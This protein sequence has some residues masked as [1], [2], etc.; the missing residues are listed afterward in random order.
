MDW[1]EEAAATASLGNSLC[2]TEEL[3]HNRD[4]HQ[5]LPPNLLK[6][7]KAFNEI[8]HAHFDSI[9]VSILCILPCLCGGA[10]VS[11]EKG[12]QGRAII[13]YM[14]LL[15]PSGVGKTS[16]AMM[17]RKYFL[18]WL[19]NE[20]KHQES[21]VAQKQKIKNPDVFLDGASAEGLEASFQSGSAPHLVMDEFGKFATAS[22]NDVVKL[23]FLRMIMQIYDSGTLVTRKLKDSNRSELLM[24]KGMGLFAASTIGRSNLTPQDMRNMIADGLLNRFLVIFGQYKR[25][26]L[27]QE[28]TAAQ[29]KEVEIFSREFHDY[30]RE[31]Q[32]YLGT[33]ALNIYERF[34]ETVNEKY[35]Q[36]YKAEDDTAGMDVRS[37]TVVQ[38][39][40]MLFQVCKNME[41]GQAENREVEA[42]SMIRAVQLL[43]YLDQNHFDQILLYANSKD[44]RPTLEDRVL[45]EIQK[46]DRQKVRDIV[47][48]LNGVKTMDV[49][50]AVHM[51]V[52]AGLAIQDQSGFISKA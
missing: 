44:G 32:F 36:K 47:R 31:K 51:L 8:S 37:L 6:V 28:L 50:A 14:L 25:I 34:H 10:T 42:I 24:I 2:R 49:H 30:A 33:D 3:Y 18:N 35:Y 52:R 19:D 12:M 13:L 15:A 40:A 23:T 27:R 9:A 22:K 11:Q 45:R 16:V 29:V 20:F 4:L 48:N 1:N 17:A 41:D 26:P 21:A 5:I 39:V 43:E 7:A 46:K 38:R